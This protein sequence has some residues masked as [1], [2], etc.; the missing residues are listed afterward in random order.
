MKLFKRISD[1]TNNKWKFLVIIFLLFS[2]ISSLVRIPVFFFD[3]FSNDEAVHIVG[4]FILN[5]GGTL[6][7]DIVDN[8]PPAI[9]IFYLIAQIL[10]GEGIF[11]VHLFT[12]ILI[13]P[14]I[15]LFIALNFDRE[16]RHMAILSGIFYIV[17][18]SAFIPTDMLATNCEIIMLLFASIA[19]YFLKFGGNYG[20]FLSG[21][22]LGFAIL[23]KQ[24]A[25][26][27][28][29]VPIILLYIEKY[30]LK[31]SLIKILLFLSSLLI[32]VITILFL[33]N[34]LP[35]FIHWN[36]THN[37][38][39]TQN[40][41]GIVEVIKRIFKY[42]I[43][44]LIIISPLIYFFIK[45]S[46]KIDR[47]IL[48]IYL[49]ALILAII[50]IFAGFRLFPHYFIQMIFPLSILASAYF[51]DINETKVYLKRFLLY[52]LIIVL[53]FNIYTLYFYSKKS[54]FIEETEPA[55]REIP[56]VIKDAGLCPQNKKK[57]V[58]V[59]GYAPLFYYYFY[60]ECNMLPASRFVV[61]QASITG[62]IP[63]NESSYNGKIDPKKYIVEKDRELLLSD[64]KQNNPLIIIDTSPSGFHHW[65]K[66]PLETFNGLNAFVN[67]NYS[68]MKE[69]NGFVIYI[70]R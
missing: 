31:N 32:P 2:G 6:Y 47:Q 48:K 28:I 49:P 26:I 37:I 35:E 16:K 29:P 66:Y 46:N 11:S 52:C 41:I 15:A 67:T 59:Y 17:F 18:T 21:L 56:K 20:L 14:L 8:K 44:Y 1:A 64:L 58:F 61:P 24:Q 3:F 65:D 60:M 62:Y 23:G 43:P 7:R 51:K 4:S 50:S 13:I 36:L 68:K 34:A 12:T 38:K 25:A 70:R 69:L 30:S 57:D 42:L 53:M 27:W 54:S 9:Y 19:F 40:P 33:L 63:G 45:G 55:F 22:F 10:F 39:Y 5:N